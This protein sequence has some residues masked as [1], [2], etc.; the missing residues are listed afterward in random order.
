VTWHQRLG[1]KRLGAFEI[2]FENPQGRKPIRVDAFSSR[3][4][5]ERRG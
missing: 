3:I 4:A 5:E 2:L 1:I